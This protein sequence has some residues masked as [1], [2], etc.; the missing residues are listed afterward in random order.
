MFESESAYNQLLE[1]QGSVSPIRNFLRE[2][3]KRNEKARKEISVSGNKPELVVALRRAV[4]LNFATF[5]EVG[6]LLSEIEESGHQRIRYFTP[7]KGHLNSFQAEEVA[8]RLFDE[9]SISILFPIYDFPIDGYQWVDFRK[10][11]NGDW[12]AKMYG[13]ENLRRRVGEITK[14]IEDGIE[15]EIRRYKAKSTKL[16]LIAKWRKSL[17]VLEIRIDVQGSKREEVYNRRA[18][19]ILNSISRAIPGEARLHWNIDPI[20]ENIL[21]NRQHENCKNVYSISR[22]D[23]LDPSTG[24]TRIYPEADGDFDSSEGRTKALAQQLSHGFKPTLIKI[25]W[26]C[27]LE[28]CPKC[29]TKPVNVVLE[30]TQQGPELR[31]QGRVTKQ[32]YEYIFNQLRSRQ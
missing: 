6:D 20:L 28:E 12:L 27:G 9:V 8:E 26:E 7:A 29:M 32:T 21:V 30:K 18:N 16:I 4:A 24:S 2:V 1:L 22:V 14:T 5:K 13:R 3:Q 11:G 15:V 19:S 25:K 23:L 10:L 31:I 17:K